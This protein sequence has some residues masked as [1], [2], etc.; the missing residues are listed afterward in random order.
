MHEGAASLASELDNLA[1]GVGSALGSA[2]NEFENR[3]N[4]YLDTRNYA[5]AMEVVN[6]AISFRGAL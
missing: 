5:E 1:A 4:A 3:Y 6:A 2:T